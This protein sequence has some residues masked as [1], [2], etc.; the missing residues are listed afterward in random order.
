MR[1][2]LSRRSQVLNRSMIVLSAAAVVA[3]AALAWPL[4]AVSRSAVPD[5]SPLPAAEWAALRQQAAAPIHRGAQQEAAFRQRVRQAEAEL[6]ALQEA[7]AKDPTRPTTAQV[8][9]QLN[10]MVAERGDVPAAR[11]EREVKAL[12]AL[13]LVLAVALGAVSVSNLRRARSTAVA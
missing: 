8:Q 6:K 13:S 7:A 5:A 2:G 1:P 4:I 3:L 10:R 12:L 9:R 11:L